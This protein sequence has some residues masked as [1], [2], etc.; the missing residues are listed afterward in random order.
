MFSVSESLESSLVVCR[1]EFQRWSDIYAGWTVTWL[2]VLELRSI[3]TCC[4]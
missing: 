2:K 3:A 4:L 1:D